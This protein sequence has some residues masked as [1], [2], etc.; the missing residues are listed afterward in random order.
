MRLITRDGHSI[1]YV[2]AVGI[3]FTLT[4]KLASDPKPNVLFFNIILYFQ[5][6]VTNLEL[7]PVA[8][9]EP[10]NFW[11][12]P[13]AVSLQNNILNNSPICNETQTQS[14]KVWTL[15]RL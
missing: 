6:L 8:H 11:I 10:A 1:L 7:E 5:V 2:R 15:P 9:L 12:G 3:A 4:R 13:S 14:A